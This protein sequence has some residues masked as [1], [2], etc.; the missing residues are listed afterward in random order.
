[1]NF[2]G[3]TIL[4][5]AAAPAPVVTIVFFLLPPPTFAVAAPASC[6]P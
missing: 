3:A 6:P 2:G 4:G 5:L 1:M